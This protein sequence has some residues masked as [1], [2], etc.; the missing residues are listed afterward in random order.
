M[1]SFEPT[2]GEKKSLLSYNKLPCNKSNEIIVCRLQYD[3][4]G[5][6]LFVFHS[7]R[8]IGSNVLNIKGDHRK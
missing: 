6:P 2:E 7:P 4:Q 3:N 5:K 1:E 8:E